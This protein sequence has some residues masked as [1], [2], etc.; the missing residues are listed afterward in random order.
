LAGPHSIVPDEFE[1]IQDLRLRVYE[2]H[3]YK[4]ELKSFL[5]KRTALFRGE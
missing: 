1:R 3:D 2:G 5:E 4:E